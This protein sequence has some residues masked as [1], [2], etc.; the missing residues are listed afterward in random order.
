[1]R[2]KMSMGKAWALREIPW[3][4]GAVPVEGLV[5]RHTLPPL[6]FIPASLNLANA[7]YREITKLTVQVVPFPSREQIG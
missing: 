1:M 2:E 5:L 6:M 4:G 3:G 7:V